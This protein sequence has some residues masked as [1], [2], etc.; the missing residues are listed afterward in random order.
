[1]AAGGGGAHAASHLPAGSDPL[2]TAVWTDELNVFTRRQTIAEPITSNLALAPTTPG[3]DSKRFDIVTNGA[4]L[5]FSSMTD[6]GIPITTGFSLT[7]AG[8]AT[9]AGT[10]TAGGDEV[11]THA[12]GYPGGTT[13]FLRADGTFAAASGGGGAFALIFRPQATSRRR[14]PSPRS[15][16]ATRTRCSTSTAPPTRRRCLRRCSRRATRGAG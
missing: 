12:G 3:V 10:L 15:T 16:R 4:V 1:M 2:T 5:N 13:S 9:V 11:L 7:R 8:D 14:P 6:A